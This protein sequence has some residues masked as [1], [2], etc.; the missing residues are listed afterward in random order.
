MNAKR[1][2]AMVKIT[3]MQLTLRASTGSKHR[4]TYTPNKNY[5]L[6]H[7]YKVGANHTSI[8]CDKPASGHKIDA[9]RTNNM[10]GS[11]RGKEWWHWSR[12]HSSVKVASCYNAYT[13]DLS[14]TTFNSIADSGCNSHFLLPDS[15]CISKVPTNDGIRVKLPNGSI[16]T[17]T[18]TALLDLPDLPLAARQSHIFPDV[19]SSDTY[20]EHVSVQS[21][22]HG[23]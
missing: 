7:G 22:P 13:V 8:R 9:T 23:S 4:H 6:T 17:A 16:I 2:D 12:L 19:T 15:H 21:N 14:S 5:C 20:T 1:H 11:Q 18:H 10:G 3:G